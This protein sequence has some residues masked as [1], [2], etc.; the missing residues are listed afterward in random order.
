[1]RIAILGA[2]S[3]IAKDLAF[4]FSASSE[5]DLVLYARRPEVV[6]AWLK[7]VKTYNHYSIMD[8]NAFSNDEHFDV[9]LNFIG[10]GN[11]ALAIAMGT[12][13][14]DITLK[15]DELALDFIQKH[16]LCRYIFLSSGAAFGTKFDMPVNK[17]TM[18]VVAIN[19]L[20]HQDWYGIAKLYAECRHRALAH[21]NIVD[22]R[23]FNYFSHTQNMEERFFITD[24]LRALKNKNILKTSSDPMVRDY[25]SPSDFYRL[26]IS[27]LITP[28]TNAVIDCYSKAPID[29]DT[30]LAAFQ[31]EFGLKYEIVKESVGLNATGSKSRYYSLNTNAAN[32]GYKPLLTS[33]ESLLKETALALEHDCLSK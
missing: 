6:S 33:L 14:F 28:A 27:V 5:H 12:S 4:S 21:L 11:P 17:D 10:V 18:A 22:I 3:Q 24:V 13:I 1:M 20:Q 16:P 15:Y 32:F 29:K 8:L 30:L 9:I 26:I 7:N 19:D 25:I 2:T 23:V 31:D